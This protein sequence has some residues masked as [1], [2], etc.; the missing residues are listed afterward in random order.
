MKRTIILTLSAFLLCSCFERLEFGADYKPEESPGPTPAEHAVSYPDDGVEVKGVVFESGKD[1]HI[2]FRI[3]AITE[4][5]EGTLL[6]FCEARNTIAD[7]YTGHESQF[8]GITPYQ[9]GDSKDTG[10]IDLVLKRS[11]DG[12]ATWGPMITI[13][14]DG[15][16]VCGNPAPV[17]DMGTGRIWLFWCWQKCS[18]QPSLLFTSILDGHTRRVVCCYSDDDGLSWSSPVDMTA[19]LKDRNWTWYAT[20]PCHATQLVS[21]THAGRM[22]VP[23]NHRDAANKV[24]YSHCFFSDDHGKTWTLG[25]NTEKGGNESCIA[26]LSD[27]S[28]LTGMRIAGDDLPDGVNTKCRAFSKST[29]GG[30]SWGSFDRVENL[31]D[32]GCQGAI[33]NYHK[34]GEVPS[35]TIL[36]S[37]C[38]NTSRREMSISLSKDDG[39]TWTTPYTVTLNRS[40]YSDIIVLYDGSVAL[41]Y[42]NGY[43]KY[44]TANPNEQISFLRIPPSMVSSKLGL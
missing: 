12:G 7:F 35:S 2:Y 36:L 28:I 44:G 29:D 23:A 5:K 3:P 37:N 34:G 17:V 26:E 11:T 10:D 24:N 16:N 42:E 41:F 19:T 43:G 38:H 22:I 13:F 18:G 25:G 9:P 27:G 32:P 31:T 4:T 33:A 20:G 14:D 30:V 39:K 1:N 8:P 40:A 6:A 21:G 15:N